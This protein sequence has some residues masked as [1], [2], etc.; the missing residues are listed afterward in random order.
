[1]EL[2]EDSTRE[3]WNLALKPYR[4][5]ASLV[6]GLVIEADDEVALVYLSNAQTIALAMENLS[7]ARPFL[8]RDRVGT[9]PQSVRARLQS[10]AP[11]DATR[12]TCPARVAT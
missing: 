9:A 2:G 3:Q 10:R 8:S 11:I 4:P 7:W 12:S 6:P 1:M 5:I